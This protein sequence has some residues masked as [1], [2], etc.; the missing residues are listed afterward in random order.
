[1]RKFL[2]LPVFLLLAST[3]CAAGSWSTS[4]RDQ[5]RDACLNNWG[6][7]RSQCECVV[8]ATEATYPDVR[9]FSRSTAPSNELL[10]NLASCGVGPSSNAM[11]ATDTSTP[12]KTAT[13]ANATGQPTHIFQSGDTLWS[14]AARYLGAGNRWPEIAQLNGIGDPN[15]ISNGTPILIPGGAL[16]ATPKA[17]ATTR[18]TTATVCTV[19][20]AEAMTAEVASLNRDYHMEAEARR[21][22]EEMPVYLAEQ[23]SQLARLET[24]VDQLRECLLSG[25]S[26]SIQTFWKAFSEWIDAEEVVNGIAVGCYRDHADPIG[27]MEELIVSPAGQRLYEAMA[28]LD[29]A[30]RLLG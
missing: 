7:T 28:N 5:V 25:A 23:Q 14:L 11:G 22:I 2:F 6:G 19:D 17:P 10:T 20:Q 15:G 12:A 9:D 30:K 1:M 29:E 4:E 3:A 13:N 16:T 21:R 8:D 26:S 24:K 27:C 18:A